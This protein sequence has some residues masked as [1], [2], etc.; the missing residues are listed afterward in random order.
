MTEVLTNQWIP[1]LTAPIKGETPYDWS[2]QWEGQ[3]AW[4]A[5]YRIMKNG[6]PAPCYYDRSSK[7]PGYTTAK[8]WMDNFRE[9]WERVYISENPNYIPVPG[10]I[11]VFNGVFNLMFS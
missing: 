11:I 9:P 6:W 8:L 4:G 10:D 7:T 2:S 3:C 1:I 5:Y